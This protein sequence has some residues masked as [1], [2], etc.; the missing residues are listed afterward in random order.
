MQISIQITG[1]QEVIAKIN[2]LGL[3]LLMF[4]QAMT[5]IGEDLT[6]YYSGQAFLSQGGVYGNVWQRLAAS[7]NL[8][9]SKHYAGAPP[10][11][12]T[13]KMMAGFRYKADSKSVF[14]Y[15][16]MPYFGYQQLGTSRMPARQLIGV[17]KTITTMIGDV[18]KKDI[19]RKLRS[20]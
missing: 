4:D 5:T 13:G 18:I 19:E 10:E 6:A 1:T 11:V 20:L 14:V 16:R 9:K 17:N 15:N 7:T 2:K 12:E 8:F 3:K